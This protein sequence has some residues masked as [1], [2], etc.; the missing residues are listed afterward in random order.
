[1][2][3]CKKA[4]TGSP[5]HYIIYLIMFKFTGM[6]WFDRESQTLMERLIK[7]VP[8]YKD[9]YNLEPD[10]VLVPPD[11]YKNEI[12]VVPD[13]NVVESKLLFGNNIMLCNKYD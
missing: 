9:K 3:K 8:Y 6:L 4:L 2:R 11:K 10:V 7:A 13:I 12:I 5:I 1:M